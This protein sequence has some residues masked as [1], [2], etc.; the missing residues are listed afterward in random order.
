MAYSIKI[1]LPND[2]RSE[3]LRA[4]F[5]QL[6]ENYVNNRSSEDSLYDRNKTTLKFKFE[7]RDVQTRSTVYTVTRIK[8]LYLSNDPE[9]NQSS[10]F[11][12]DSFPSSA[13]DDTLDY[14]LELNQNFLLYKLS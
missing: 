5:L 2:L 9:F 12:I 8:T 13:Y 6:G 11:V 3:I 14:T 10:T 1:V 7:I 4:E